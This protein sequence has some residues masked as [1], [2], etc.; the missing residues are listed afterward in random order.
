MPISPSDTPD[1]WKYRIQVIS[2]YCSARPKIKFDANIVALSSVL[3]YLD[4]IG[5][6]LSATF[7]AVHRIENQRKK[8]ERRMIFDAAKAVRN[9]SKGERRFAATWLDEDEQTRGV[10]TQKG[11]EF[12]D[13]HILLDNGGNLSDCYK[14]M[15][16]LRRAILRDYPTTPTVAIVYLG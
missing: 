10:I 9:V 16:D 12:A 1:V 3:E 6:D 14:S 2:D 13:G 8:K 4:S 15:E 7:E 5:V 11:T